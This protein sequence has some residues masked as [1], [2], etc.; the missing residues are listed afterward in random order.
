MTT[1][2]RELRDALAEALFGFFSPAGDLPWGAVHPRR[3]EEWRQR[4]DCF[5]AEALPSVK[6]KM[7]WEE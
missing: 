4:A 2:A 3:K 5:C 7:G 1:P 6:L